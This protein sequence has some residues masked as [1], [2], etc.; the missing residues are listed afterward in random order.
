MSNDEHAESDVDL[1]LA[2]RE[3]REEAYAPYSDFSVGAALRTKD[4]TIV[5]GSNV[6]NAS[7]GLSMCAERVALF[8]AASEGY[9][10]P[11][12]LAVAGDDED[13]A[14]PCGACR[15]VM[16][17]FNGEMRIV[18]GTD[19]GNLTVKTLSDLLPDSFGPDNLS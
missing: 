13:P 8:K 1:F 16:R 3:A 14:P 2:A 10:Y 9:R 19:P 4:G 6:E 7:Y 12:A 17:E 5:T 11:E 15:Q 18:Y